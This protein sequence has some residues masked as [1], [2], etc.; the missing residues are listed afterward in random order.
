MG[1]SGGARLKKIFEREGIDALFITKSANQRYLEGFTGTDCFLIASSSKNF[2]IADS[3]YTEM[4]RD[5]CRTAEV[6]R[7]RPPHPPLARVV[8]AIAHDNGY[9]R[10]G[11]ERDLMTW[12][13]YDEIRA[14]AALS[15][16]ELVPT[17]SVI[18]GMRAI[19][20]R[21]EIAKIEDSCRIAD[22]AL[23]ELLPLVRR[24]V[25]ELDLR[26]EL[27]YR[28]KKL[29]A[30]DVSFETMLLF[31]ARASQ[32]HACSRADVHLMEGDFILIDYGAC[33][34]GYRS[35]TT[36]TFVC[37]HASP[38]QRSAY[39]AVLKSQIASLEM[40]SRGAN[41]RE[42]NALAAGILKRDGLPPFE[43]GVGH[44]VG[45]EIH[46]QPFL[47]QSA[48]VIL[49]D[50]MVV[51]IEPG[52]YKPGWGGIRIEDTILVTRSRRILTLFP[53]E[54]IEL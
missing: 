20:T 8:A 7:H 2:L 53:K 28:L 48:D 12:G 43:H 6:V 18:E 33:K 42:I 46:E 11:F 35:D 38:E 23:E 52:T 40:I 37:G 3:R 13:M 25:S 45:L 32:P 21:E 51:T 44:G 36:R 34:D 30:D 9:F 5:E 54:L 4:A 26:T 29:G 16:V 10:L 39:G 50:G 31:G 19:K 15:G 47:R 41:G 27:D 1:K 14:E 49:E 22:R 17:T 24:G